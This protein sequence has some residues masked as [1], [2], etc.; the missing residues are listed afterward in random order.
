MLFPQES[1]KRPDTL[2]MNKERSPSPHEVAAK[3]KK[4]CTFNRE[5]SPH[6]RKRVTE[7]NRMT[8]LCCKQKETSRPAFENVKNQSQKRKTK[9]GWW[10][11]KEQGKSVPK[12]GIFKGKIKS[13]ECLLG[14]ANKGKIHMG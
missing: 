14:L 12:R 2:P 5:P 4:M 7:Q 13:M 8:T 10:L 6:F 3:S 11:Q 9:I 1:R